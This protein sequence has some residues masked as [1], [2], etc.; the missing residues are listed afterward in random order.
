M[1][2]PIL[3]AYQLLTGLS[4]ALTGALLIIAAAANAVMVSANGVTDILTNVQL[5]QFSTGPDVATAANAVAA[6]P[7]PTRA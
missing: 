1:N 2:R 6:L 3:L 4:D 7:P 5:L